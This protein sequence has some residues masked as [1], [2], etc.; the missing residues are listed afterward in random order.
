MS[1]AAARGEHAVPGRVRAPQ[2][3]EGAHKR[4]VGGGDMVASSMRT[5]SSSHVLSAARSHRQLFFL[6]SV[7]IAS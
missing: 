3:E 1:D 7:P 6:L 4:K 5:I 2:E